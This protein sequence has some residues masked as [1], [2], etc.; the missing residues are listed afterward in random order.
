MP[1]KRFWW[2]KLRALVEIRDW[3]GVA[4]LAKSKKSPIGYEPFV[5]E[6]VKAMQYREAAK[7]ILKCDAHLRAGLFLKIEAYQEA[8]EQAF[9]QKD[10]ETLKEIRD[11]CPNALLQGQIDGYITQLASSR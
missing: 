5:E 7:Y 1:D 8:G 4:T 3:D 11:K 2:I 10:L 6:C 9:L